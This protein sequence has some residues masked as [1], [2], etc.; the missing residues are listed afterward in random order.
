MR[1]M[2]Q[3][4]SESAIL[5]QLREVEGPSILNSGPVC[6]S[7]SDWVCLDSNGDSRLLMCTR[8]YGDEWSLVFDVKERPCVD[9]LLRNVH[10]ARR[11]RVALHEDVASECSEVEVTHMRQ[12]R[13]NDDKCL[14]C[15]DADSLA[16]LRAQFLERLPT[17]P[18]M[19]MACPSE[20]ALQV[21]MTGNE[22]Q[23][24]TWL[25]DPN[26]WESISCGLTFQGKWPVN[27][28]IH[29][30]DEHLARTKSALEQ[31]GY[32]CVEDLAWDNVGISMQAI[33]DTMEAL[34]TRG[35]PPVFVFMYDEAWLL[36]ERLFGM[37]A[38][39]LG[40]ADVKLDASIFAW[41]LQPGGGK[42]AVG[43]NFGRPHRDDSY[44]DCHS[45]DGRL[46]VLS[47]WLPV[48]PVST[49]SGCMYVVPASH[50]PLFS[51]PEHEHHMQPEKQMPWA[52]IR[53]L[54]AAAGD[55]LMWKG[56][57][58]HWGSACDAYVEQP[59]KSVASAFYASGASDE[60]E[61]ISRLR[62]RA[63]L[64]THVRLK[65]IIRALLTYERWHPGFGGL[66][67]LKQGLVK[68]P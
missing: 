37:A 31:S 42:G 17:R 66:D 62:L 56:N 10:I 50:D 49:V 28:D 41:A 1:C 30:I 12:P 38:A 16:H 8:E 47:V 46:K 60:L 53:A 35:L 24:P 20:R 4:R 64:A 29:L 40:D 18:S 21:L 45:A 3:V 23:L 65:L 33:A 61:G 59:R 68:W 51:Q 11:I 22:S 54:P 26:L 9:A 58:I 15:T 57:L 39:I 5:V 43:N 44:S 25:M 27:E 36:W 14:D 7:D 52:H 6:L 67:L 34:R 55:V 32:S 63:G 19:P 48:V 2:M 13:Q